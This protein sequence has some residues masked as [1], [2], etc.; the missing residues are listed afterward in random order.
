MGRTKPVVQNC[1]NRTPS[2][3][4]IFARISFNRG[5]L[6]SVPR[7]LYQML[8][9]AELQRWRSYGSLS[10]VVR[11]ALGRANVGIEAVLMALPI[12]NGLPGS[13]RLEQFG[14]GRCQAVRSA[15]R[16]ASAFA[17]IPGRCQD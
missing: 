10:D 7:P 14:R 15:G 13:R 16:F 2:N 1:L 8:A 4:V 11:A 5:W 17:D 6:R 9:L 3:F 12:P